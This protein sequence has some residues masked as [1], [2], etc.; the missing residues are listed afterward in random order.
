M[1][2]LETKCR[3]WGEPPGTSEEQ[4]CQNAETA[5]KSAI[6]ASDALKNR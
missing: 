4:R 1:T 6:S 3:A 2:G 5:I